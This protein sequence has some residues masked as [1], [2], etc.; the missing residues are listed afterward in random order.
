MFC[1]PVYGF[2]CNLGERPMDAPRLITELVGLQSPNGYV[3]S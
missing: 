2:V 3:E 1:F